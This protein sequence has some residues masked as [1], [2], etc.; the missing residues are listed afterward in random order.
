MARSLA[1]FASAISAAALM[2]SS[3]VG[4]A[5]PDGDAPSTSQFVTLGTAGGPEP[6]QSRSQPANLLMV[7]KDAFLV[8]AG[9]GAAGQL[10]K[11]GVP[12]GR[13]S[14]LFVS[15][16]HFDHSAGVLAIIALR[17]QMNVATPLRIFG[18]PGTKAFVDGL[19]TSMQPE[20]RLGTGVPGEA[21]RDPA[22]SVQVNELLDGDVVT[23][24]AAKVTA[25][26]NSHYGVAATA[27]RKA[28][29]G[30]LAFRFDLPDRS[31]V[32]TGDTGPSRAVEDLSRDADLLVCEMID[33]ARME[34]RLRG[35]GLA[36]GAA[37][38]DRL[39]IHMRTHH[40]TPEA[41][42]D[43]ARAAGVKAVVVT[44]L[45]GVSD[46][47]ADQAGYTATIRDRFSG[48]VALA[49]DLDRF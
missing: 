37:Q 18:P 38:I 17:Y 15:H 40:L 48:S 41:V 4:A 20:A 39:M 14:G 29:S 47:A 5:A 2:A 34:R 45:A 36:G 21:H 27:D 26:G 22:A 44:H 35:S 23:L 6:Q 30:S 16:L 33:V 8:D 28:R 43:L 3:P 19:V 31:I 13:L 7:G 25:R 49:H 11:A 1:G 32:Y 9:D 10:A 12:L 46:D 24:G 42:G